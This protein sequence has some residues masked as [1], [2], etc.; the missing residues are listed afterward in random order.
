MSKMMTV[1][2]FLDDG[3]IISQLPVVAVEECLYGQR[4]IVACVEKCFAEVMICLGDGMVIK[5]LV[6]TIETFLKRIKNI[7]AHEA[8]VF[9]DSILK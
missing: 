4:C 1:R 5:S 9:I 3:L 2:Q 7:D 6:V 8:F